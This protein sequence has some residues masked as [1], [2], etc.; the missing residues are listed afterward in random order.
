MKLRNRLVLIAFLS[1]LLVVAK[2]A[3]S[4]VPNVE[5]VTLLL[6]VYTKLLGCKTTLYITFIFTTIQAIIYPPHLWVITYY[7][8]WPTLVVGAGLLFKLKP[9][10]YVI[11]IYAAVFGLLFGAFDSVILSFVYGFHTFAPIWIRGLPWDLVHGFSNYLT[12]LLLYEPLKKNLEK[13]IF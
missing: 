4:V 1:A 6:L 13:L 3:L 7:L 9:N 2:E 11:A 8:I 10:V 12:A 5:V